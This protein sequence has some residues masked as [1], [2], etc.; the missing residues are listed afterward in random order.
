MTSGRELIISGKLLQSCNSVGKGIEASLCVLQVK[1]SIS[2]ER[3][4][5][6]FV[7]RAVTG[8]VELVLDLPPNLAA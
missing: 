8:S 1:T 7:H 5:A 3:A 2:L 4:A 6:F